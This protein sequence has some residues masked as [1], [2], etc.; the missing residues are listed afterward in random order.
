MEPAVSLRTGNSLSDVS[1]PTNA[2]GGT[3]ASASEAYGCA[4]SPGD[5]TVLNRKSALS[6]CSLIFDSSLSRIARR[7]WKT[8]RCVQLPHW[9]DRPAHPTGNASASSGSSRSRVDQ[10]GLNDEPLR[11][12]PDEFE[13]VAG[14]QRHGRVVRGMEHVHVVGP[15][16]EG[17]A[18]AVAV[19]AI[20]RRD[21]QG[22]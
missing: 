2:S 6:A 13:R 17:F 16:D 3:T 14:D 22:I 12:V 10:F 1:A 5:A 4:A 8:E 21:L 20:G 11:S 15:D 9:P 18:D 19:V 7:L